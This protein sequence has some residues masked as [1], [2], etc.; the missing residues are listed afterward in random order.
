MALC[1]EIWRCCLNLILDTSIWY[2]FFK[3]WSFGEKHTFIRN[4]LF[5]SDI[6]NRQQYLQETIT[7]FYYPTWHW[8]W[9]QD[10]P[11]KN[12]PSFT[13]PPPPKKKVVF[14]FFAAG[15]HGWFRP[16]GLCL[17][18]QKAVGGHKPEVILRNWDPPVSPHFC[19]SHT[20]PRTGASFK[21]QWGQFIL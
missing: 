21:C 18:R 12:L 16:V 20:F 8:V 13:R 5:K 10:S 6:I 9:L 3:V 1:I 17:P 15:S 19:W 14:P 4:W 11:E 2:R 7:P